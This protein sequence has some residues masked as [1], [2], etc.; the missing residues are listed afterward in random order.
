[1]PSINAL[2]SLRMA[3]L[4]TADVADL[5]SCCVSSTSPNHIQY[6]SPHAGAHFGDR[7]CQATKRACPPWCCTDVLAMG[8]TDVRGAPSGERLYHPRSR[9]RGLVGHGH[10]RSR[11]WLA[12]GLV[13]VIMRRVVARSARARACSVAACAPTLASRFRTHVED[14]RQAGSTSA[15]Y[16]SQPPR[17]SS[18]SCW[19]RRKASKS[20]VLRN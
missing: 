1:M 5:K 9:E 7:H 8:V 4:A 12:A 19:A 16:R 17:S 20:W 18:W 14:G 3:L 15:D 10:R 11:C 13:L 6:G 2:S